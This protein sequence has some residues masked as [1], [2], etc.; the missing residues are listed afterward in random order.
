[1]STREKIFG[2]NQKSL[3]SNEGRAAIIS[4]ILENN[5]FLKPEEVQQALSRA[6][7]LGIVNNFNFY[8]WLENSNGYRRATSDYYNL[9]KGTWNIFDIVDRLPHFNAIFQA[10]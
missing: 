1:M 4:A 5:E 7:E 2:I 3:G 9:I 8:K 10:F 6:E